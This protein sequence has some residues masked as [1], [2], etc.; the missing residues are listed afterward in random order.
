MFHNFQGLVTDKVPHSP[1]FADTKVYTWAVRW[2]IDGDVAEQLL[3]H[4]TVYEGKF[5][6]RDYVLYLI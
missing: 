4:N 5:E 2:V 3:K 6:D 1:W